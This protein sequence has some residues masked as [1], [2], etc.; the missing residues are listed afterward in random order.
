[1]LKA[2]KNQSFIYAWDT[3][4]DDKPFYCPECK[5][6]LGI[7]K[8]KIKIHH[9]YHIRKFNC[10]M[11]NE[12]QVHYEVKYFL[13]K[14]FYNIY[15]F[16][17][18]EHNLNGRVADLFYINTKGNKTA[19]EIQKSNLSIEEISARTN[20]YREKGIYVIWLLIK[21]CLNFQA[22]NEK[23]IKLTKWQLFIL[24]LYKK[25]FVYHDGII[26]EYYLSDTYSYNEYYD[27]F[28]NHYENSYK[29]KTI[30]V[31]KEIRVNRIIK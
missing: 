4:R 19:Y 16:V 31:I 20:F 15:K 28:G 26:Y 14:S 12:S 2:L 22:N 17:D 18:I 8:G 3:N 13:Y 9:F 7:R 11:I 27:S 10:N 23:Y 6:E 25:L 29:L 24:K 5:S 1:M 21:D 30:K